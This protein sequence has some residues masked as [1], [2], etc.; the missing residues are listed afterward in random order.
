M[1]GQV[2]VIAGAPVIVSDYLTADLNA[3][4]V[5]DNTTKTRTGYLLVN[6]DAYMM[7]N[8]KPLTIDVDREI[9]NGAVE[10]VATRRTIFKCM[11]ES[12]KTVAF[13]FD[14]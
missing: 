2:A 14:L 12:S 11:E 1:T 10:V 8:Y 6:R 5:Y 13:A 9:V 7:G 3:S 4:G